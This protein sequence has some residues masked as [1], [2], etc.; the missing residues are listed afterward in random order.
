MDLKKKT[1]SGMLLDGECKWTEVNYGSPVFD[2]KIVRGYFFSRK[3]IES[4]NIT[5][6]VK[7]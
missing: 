6:K 4:L 7:K 3:E 5:L 1:I 2:G